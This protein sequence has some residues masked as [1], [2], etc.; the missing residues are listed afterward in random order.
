M[1]GKSLLS[2]R[3]KQSSPH[4]EKKM[5]ALASRSSSGQLG[6]FSGVFRVGELSK[7]ESRALK[8]LLEKY[9]KDTSTFQNDINIIT[10]VTQEV[11]AINSQAV[12]LHGE[13]IK[14]VQ[15]LLAPYKDGAFS[16]WLM[17]AYGNRQTPYNFLQYF[18]LHSALDTLHQQKIESMPK[19]AIYTLASRNASLEEKSK[20]IGEYA[21]QTKQQM[22][23]EIRERFPLEG[24]D[25]RKPAFG[26][27]LFKQVELLEKMVMNRKMTISSLY[28]DQIIQKLKKI[29][30]YLSNE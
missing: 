7:D 22:L 11:K 17:A 15:T 5:S 4:A 30:H 2:E 25:K 29:T 16:A 27:T 21:G 20:V 10:S 8:E 24:K 19:Q 13:R 26:E 28:K 14:T 12:I 1:A 18:E 9:S 23:Q 3:M 6:G